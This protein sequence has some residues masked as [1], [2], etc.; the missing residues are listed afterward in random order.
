MLVVCSPKGK[1]IAI[2]LN[3]G[4]D[5]RRFTTFTLFKC[6]MYHFLQMYI[7]N[8]LTALLYTVHVL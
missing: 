6:N 4:Y 3:Q 7:Q 5:L 8:F 1:N 2:Y